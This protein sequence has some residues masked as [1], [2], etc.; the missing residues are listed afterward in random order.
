MNHYY[1]G[2]NIVQPCSY[3]NTVREKNQYRLEYNPYN[4]YNFYVRN[5]RIVN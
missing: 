3:V 1:V 2:M 4:P 5:K